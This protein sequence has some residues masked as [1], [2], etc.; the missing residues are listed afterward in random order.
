LAEKCGTL[1]AQWVDAT[2]EEMHDRID[3]MSEAR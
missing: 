3:S 2:A 1:L